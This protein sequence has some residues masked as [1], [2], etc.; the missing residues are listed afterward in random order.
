[1]LSATAAAQKCQ[2]AAKGHDRPFVVEWDATDLASFEAKAQRD[3][4]VVRYKGCEME[5]LHQCSDAVV[6]GKFGSY[7]TP[8][9]T[10][11]T[12]QGFEIKNEGEL[13]AKLPL[14]AARLS[15]RIS[16]GE[17]LR[18]KYFIAGVASS[19][20]EALYEEDLKRIPGCA[21]ATHFVWGY[22]LGAFELITKQ[23]S[24]VEASA[25]IEVASVGGKRSHEES[26]AGKGGNLRACETQDQR[27]CRVP[28][29]LG[30]RPIT[31]GTNPVAEAAPAAADAQATGAGT[32]AEQAQ[33]M[34]KHAEE[35]LDKGDGTG[36]VAAMD[37]AMSL[38]M[39]LMDQHKFKLERAQCQMAAGKCDDGTKDFRAA[40]AAA[41]TKR[42][43]QEFQLD[44]RT[45]EVA[46]K[47]CP[48]ATARND[49]DF[50]ERAVRELKAAATVNDGPRC[51]ALSQAIT[52]RRVALQKEG[53]ADKPDFD[54]RE[55]ADN[56]ASNSYE[57]AAVCVVKS[58]KKCNDGLPIMKSACKVM[59]GTMVAACE[60]ASA[61]G[62]KRTLEFS[63]P[64]CK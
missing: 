41:D 20:R 29:R 39:R 35:L 54:L 42:E 2:E 16:G 38:D 5:V 32:P 24:A 23:N 61:A 27:G 46:N 43:L 1:M 51:K 55:R 22:N 49:A 33:A 64:E 44:R 14:G 45:R 56:L 18:L 7:G 10:S 9:F 3:T 52:E 58:T 11:G 34:W 63:K 50:L 30:L 17:E 40:L 36:C 8:Q 37:K 28:I 62:W 15:G 26:V 21:G 31:P 57:T 13:Y 48:S 59:Q 19:S 25:G 12:E 47:R 60:S 4:V 53:T 6:A